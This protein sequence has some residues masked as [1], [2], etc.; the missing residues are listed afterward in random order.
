MKNKFSINT[1]TEINALIDK[2]QEWKEFFEIKTELFF[3]GWAISLREKSMYPRSIIIF[4]SYDTNNY[5]IRSFEIHFKNYQ[6]EE[7]KELYS[8][9][10]INNINT[11]VKE[12]KEIIYGKDLMKEASKIYNGVFNN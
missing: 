3:D 11:L 1:Q 4:K 7:Y 10:D 9:E 6:K 8:I 12:L 2:L 5:S